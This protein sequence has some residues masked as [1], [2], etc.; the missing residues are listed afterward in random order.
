M[1]RLAPYVL[2]LLFGA[3]Q[4]YGVRTGDSATA[5]LG[6]LLCLGVPA[7]TCA[8]RVARQKRGEES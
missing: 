7:A 2:M 5:W 3:V 8:L 6:A 1:K 4:L